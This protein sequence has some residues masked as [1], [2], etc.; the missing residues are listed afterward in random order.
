MC[1]GS[2]KQRPSV[3][4]IHSLGLLDLGRN[5]LHRSIPL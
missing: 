1:P 3:C 4:G 2:K 5:F